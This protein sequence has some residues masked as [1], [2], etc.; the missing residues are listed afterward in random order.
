MRKC[1]RLTVAD[2]VGVTGRILWRRCI[3]QL[4]RSRN[5]LGTPAVGKETVVSDAA[6]TVGQDVDEE[7]ADELLGVKCHKLLASDAL[8]AVILPFEG[9]AFAVVTSGCAKPA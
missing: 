1:L 8:G 3:E 7:A 6:E 9:H 2:A 5:V 4:T